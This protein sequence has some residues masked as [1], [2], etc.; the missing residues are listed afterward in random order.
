VGAAAAAGANMGRVGSKR[1]QDRDLLLHPSLS[2]L[3]DSET[4]L[5]PR[6][7][8][9][10]APRRSGDL[11][12]KRSGDLATTDRDRTSVRP[13]SRR[14]SSRRAS[15]SSGAGVHLGPQQ[16]KR[17]QGEVEA[18]V[19]SLE[20]SRPDEWMGEAEGVLEKVSGWRVCSGGCGETESYYRGSCW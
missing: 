17:L 7:S 3:M 2:R 20:L 16:L 15:G 11:V 8:G 5:V 19:A 14:S 6:R 4:V 10:L 18:L 12:P 13:S 9:D 1:Q